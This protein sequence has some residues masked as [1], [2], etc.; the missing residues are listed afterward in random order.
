MR[1]HI[2]AVGRLRAGPE[3]ALIDDYLKRFDRTG[4]ALSLGPVSVHEVEDRKGG[5]TEAEAD[6]LGRAVPSGAFL[7]ALD[8]RGRQMSSPDFASL[9]ARTRD[10]GRQDMAFV[11]GGA[12]GLAPGFRDR[13]DTLLSFGPMV[14]PHMLVRVML[15]E[16]LY[17]AASILAGA[18]YHRV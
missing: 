12:D 13:A 18:P 8:E 16:Q 3:L 5:G 15:A 10:G 9:I 4:R 2:C 14:W 1:L 11:I 7:V 17:R 6:L